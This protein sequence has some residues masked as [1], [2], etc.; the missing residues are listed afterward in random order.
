MNEKKELYRS[1]NGI[2]LGVCQGLSEWRD[3]PVWLIRLVFFISMFA[4]FFPTLLVYIVASLFIPKEPEMPFS[5]MGK[6]DIK[7]N[8]AQVRSEALFRIKEKINGLEQRT[9]SLESY[10]ISPEREWNKRL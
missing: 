8:Y 9:R 4:G 3:I 1:R 5:I 2:L 10:M 7:K 6:E